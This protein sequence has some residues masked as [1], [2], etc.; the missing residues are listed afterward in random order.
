MN[1]NPAALIAAKEFI[2][3]LAS[4]F[5]NKSGESKKETFIRA[6]LFTMFTW[7]YS[8]HKSETVIELKNEASRL[9]HTVG[10]FF[11]QA[12]K[13]I[14]NMKIENPAIYNAIKS[15]DE[16]QFDNLLDYVQTKIKLL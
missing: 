10:N 11:H 7:A 3:S 5:E 16:I 2:E 9:F 12:E 4:Q 6:G 1:S 13:D 8:N 14:K 15:L